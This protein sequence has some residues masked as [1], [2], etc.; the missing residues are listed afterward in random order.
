MPEIHS[1]S[2]LFTLERANAM[3]PLL[4]VIVHDAVAAAQG[5]HERRLWATRSVHGRTLRVDDVYDEEMLVH[6]RYL[7]AQYRQLRGYLRELRELGVSVRRATEGLIDF[8]ANLN[9]EAVY[10]CWKLGEDQV[11]FFHE[12]VGQCSHR[13]P[14]HAERQ[15][16]HGVRWTGLSQN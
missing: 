15:G 1:P 5:L 8:P 2:D 6:Q 10:L 4:R 16:P 13:C 12:H 3:L 7:D 11:H 9:G 14:L